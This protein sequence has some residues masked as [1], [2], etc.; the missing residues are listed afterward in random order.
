MY[1]ELV[2]DTVSFIQNSFFGTIYF[3]WNAITFTI[4]FPFKF[5]WNFSDYVRA[6]ETWLAHLA[7]APTNALGK[8][9]SMK[10]DGSVEA[11][12]TNE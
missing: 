9:Y 8:P 4:T 2:T 10:S 11:E 1:Y 7:T 6:Y 3:F 12:V 5:V